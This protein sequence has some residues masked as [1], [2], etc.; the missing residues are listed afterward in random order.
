MTSPRCSICGST[1]YGL[2]WRELLYVTSQRGSLSFSNSFER[3]LFLFFQPSRLAF[4]GLPSFF[5]SWILVLMH[6]FFVVILCALY[7]PVLPY[8]SL[9]TLLFN[10]ILS[11]SLSAGGEASCFHIWLRPA[12]GEASGLQPSG[13][14]SPTLFPLL[15]P[16][17]L[18]TSPSC[19][20]SA[21]GVGL[22]HARGFASDRALAAA[23]SA[24]CGISLEK[25][26]FRFMYNCTCAYMY[27]DP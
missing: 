22:R 20:P 13:I 11:L 12:G 23:F 2:I 17:S 4:P 10:K 24:T 18:G 21:F 1:H 7:S 5:I 3:L 25:Y 8:M 15:S 16:P 14:D 26:M 27:V 9:Y 19:K 6:V